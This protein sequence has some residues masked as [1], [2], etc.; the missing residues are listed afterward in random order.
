LPIS[1]GVFLFTALGSVLL[2]L[3][4]K[5][6]TRRYLKQMPFFLYI[7][8]ACTLFMCSY[9][10][11]LMRRPMMYEAAIASAL[12]FVMIGLLLLLKA[13]KEGQIRRGFLFASAFS[14]AL[15]VGCRPTVIF[16]SFV[17]PVFLWHYMQMQIPALCGRRS[18]KEIATW[19]ASLC[20]PLLIPYIIVAIPLMWYNYARFGS[21][22]EFGL[23]FSLSVANNE[24]LLLINPIGLF[25]KS[26]TGIAEYL[27]APLNFQLAFPFVTT[28]TETINHLAVFFYADSLAGLINF[29]VFW[30]LLCFP[31]ISRFMRKENPLIWSASSIMIPIG[32]ILIVACAFFSTLTNRYFVDF[33]WMYLFTAF[34]CQY[35]IYRRHADN[36]E[37]AR[38]VLKIFYALNMASIVV[39]FFLSLSGDRYGTILAPTYNYLQRIFSIVR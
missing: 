7:I 14:F 37:A 9:T 21:I 10:S 35:F 12:V 25:M 33:S 3:V 22:T 2:L 36:S 13:Q 34:F 4:W 1:V 23:V 8:C 38:I 39:A 29:P 30:A 20:A 19:F 31:G 24:T 16:A 6:F 28:K 32:L 27:A 11:F 5:E 18:K 26:L 15:A 17:L